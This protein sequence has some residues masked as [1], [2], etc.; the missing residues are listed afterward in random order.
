M[1]P[2]KPLEQKEPLP[3]DPKLMQFTLGFV[4]R[5]LTLLDPRPLEELLA[6]ALGV[7]H[8]HAQELIDTAVPALRENSPLN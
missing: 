7:S 6:D 1:N 4:A 5:H 3:I 8:E 2:S